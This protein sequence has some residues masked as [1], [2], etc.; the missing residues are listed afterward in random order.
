[1]KLSVNNRINLNIVILK[2]FKYHLKR[3][4]TMISRLFS[5]GYTAFLYDFGNSK[6]HPL[7]KTCFWSF[8]GNLK[9]LMKFQKGP[10]SERRRL[11]LLRLMHNF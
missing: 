8:Y 6:L 2:M 4:L 1:M 7:I 10:T 3:A 5:N 9:K 11:F